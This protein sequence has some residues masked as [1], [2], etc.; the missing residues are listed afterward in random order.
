MAQKTGRVFIKLGADPLRSKAGA[1]LQIGGVQR[2]MDIADDG[3]VF[4]MERIVP[5]QIVCTL[6]HVAETDLEALRA[7]RDGT[8][9]FRCDTGRI[10][11]VADA[12]FLSAGDLTNGEIEV[13]FG[14]APAVQ[15]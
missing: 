5:S 4:Y 12:A 11:T 14:G 1:R 7:F 8:I 6:I 10:Y 9:E 13:T 15:S 3:T 2:E